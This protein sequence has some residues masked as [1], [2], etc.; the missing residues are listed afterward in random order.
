LAEYQ[1]NVAPTL[2]FMT[3]YAGFVVLG[4][5]AIGAFIGIIS[6]LMA[7]RRYLRL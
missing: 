2:A 6:S 3:Y 4:M 5:I 1:I 7:T